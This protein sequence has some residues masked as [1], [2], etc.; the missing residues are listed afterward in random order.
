[1]GVA[2]PRVLNLLGR[3]SSASA[4]A[5]GLTASRWRATAEIEVEQRAVSVE[6]AHLDAGQGSGHSI[7]PRERRP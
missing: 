7:A 5:E 1:M 6:D 4:S 3:H 2:Q